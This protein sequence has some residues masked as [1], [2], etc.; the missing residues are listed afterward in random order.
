MGRPHVAPF[1]HGVH[2]EVGVGVD[3]ARIDREARHVPDPGAR[4]RVAAPAHPLDEPVP[5]H[6]R[7]VFHD[8]ARP[9]HHPGAD[10]GV[11]PRAVVP[12][13]GHR[14]GARRLL[15]VGAGGQC[16]G[17]AKQPEAAGHRCGEKWSHGCLS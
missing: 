1:G 12:D 4:G 10:Q 11:I 2:P 9:R 14:L 17:E 8:L 6:D 15:G 5:D 3:E 7:G 13:A 16:K